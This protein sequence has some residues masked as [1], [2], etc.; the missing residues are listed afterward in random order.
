MTMTPREKLLAT[1]NFEQPDQP[2]R[3][4]A[5]G[6]W[7]ETLKRWHGEGLPANIAD[8]ASAHL[9]NGFDVW[10]PVYLGADQHPGF[11]PLF[12]EQ[13]IEQDERHTIKRDFTGSVIEVFTD[14]SSA[15]PVYIE[16]PVKDRASWEEVKEC[17]DPDSPGRIEPW[18]AFIDLSINQPLPLMVSL[19]GLFGT[20]RHLLGFDNLMVAYFDQPDLL[21]DIS[22]HWLQMWKSV[23][24]QVHAKR[25]PD[26]VFLWEDMCGKN[27]PI[28]SP[29]MFDEFMSPYYNE[30]VGFLR[31]DLE[32]PGVIVD[33]D[34]DMT[35]LIPKFVEAGVNILLPFEVQAGMDVL[36]VREQWDEYMRAFE[37]ALTK[38]NTKYAPWYIIPANRKWYRNLAVAQVLVQTM[39]RLGL[40]YPEPLPDIE[41][42]V[43]PE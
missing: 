33:T 7:T 21:H 30:M 16:S 9:F 5:M 42:Y 39:E 40:R 28:I 35:L 41:S 29:A 32:I 19:C 14:G 13:I 15:I 43:I 8:I 1:I 12:D 18:Q 11:F 23:V 17:L 4:E 36:K 2:V 10:A 24:A 26:M 27:G 31:N 37:D 3:M 6:F 38:C 22:K 20:H 25:I 34:G